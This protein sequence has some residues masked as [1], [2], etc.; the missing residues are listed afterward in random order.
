MSWGPSEA[1]RRAAIFEMKYLEYADT[2]AAF[3]HIPAS[4]EVV[5]EEARRS[6]EDEITVLAHKCATLQP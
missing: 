4:R 2:L 3:G 5:R 6:V 1:L